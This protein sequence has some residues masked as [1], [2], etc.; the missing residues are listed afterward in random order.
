MEK[1]IESVH[2]FIGQL[3]NREGFSSNYLYRGQRDEDDKWE[4][5]PALFRQEKV[6]Y[7]NWSNFEKALLKTF[8]KY[9]LPF[10]D[11][12]PQ[13]KIDWMA[14]AQHHGLPTRL[15]D[16]TEN[17]L[18]ALYFAVNELDHKCNGVVWMARFGANN[19]TFDDENL[20]KM[21]DTVMVYF[22][23]VT[24][25]RMIAQRGCFTVH[26]PPEG[27]EQYRPLEKRTIGP[28]FD[29]H[30]LVKFLVPGEK[31]RD[32]K[33]E[34][35]KYGIDPLTVFPDLDGLCRKINWD[36]YR[37]NLFIDDPES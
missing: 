34:L 1:Y 7:G 19:Y 11:S 33:L 24:T 22:P 30:T 25:P 8:E 29:I 20:D 31:K 16:W 27:Q 13:R 18:V 12:I 23:S 26:K 5:T 14:L 6:L 4:L 2:D 10:I 21:K 35:D 28:T 3:P 17:P 32:L 36:I 15:L 9:A 37:R